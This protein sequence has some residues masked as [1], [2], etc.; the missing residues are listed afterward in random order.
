[1]IH[2]QGWDNGYRF[3]RYRPSIFRISGSGDAAGSGYHDVSGDSDDN[4][5]RNS[6]AHGRG[7][8]STCGTPLGCGPGQFYATIWDD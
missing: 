2:M 3:S 4:G 7:D 8:C 1:M 5:V 6:R